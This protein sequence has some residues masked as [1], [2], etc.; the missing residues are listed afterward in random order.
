MFGEQNDVLDIPTVCKMLGVSRGTIY[1]LIKEGKLPS[2]RV[3][4]CVRILKTDVIA[5]LGG[6]GGN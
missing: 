1:N 2:R 5:F 3:G 4:R 6:E